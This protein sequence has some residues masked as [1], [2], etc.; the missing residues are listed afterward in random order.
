M[1]KYEFWLELTKN[2]DLYNELKEIENDDKQIQDRFFKELEFGTGG[3]RGI[4]GAGTNRM[5]IFTI[6]RASAGV[7]EYLKT[8]TKHSAVFFKRK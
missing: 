2:T 8:V 6:S 1:N 3:L 7:A 5:N 4:L